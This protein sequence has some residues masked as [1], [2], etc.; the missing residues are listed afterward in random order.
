MAVKVI[1]EETAAAAISVVS[2]LVLEAIRE[3]PRLVLGLAAGRTMEPLYQELSTQYAAGNI[4][5]SRVT[6]FNLDEYI[7]L[8]PSDPNSYHH[9]MQEH[10]FK[11]VNLRGDNIHIPNGVARDLNVESLR[12]ERMIDKH[13]GV[14]LQLLGLGD[15][16]HVGFNEP[17][18][19]FHSRTRAVT[20]SPA[21]I[22]QNAAMFKKHKL[23]PRRAMTM[24]M[25]TIM[26]SRRCIMLVTGRHKAHILAKVLEGRITTDI[27]ATALR[28][29]R[30]CVIV[31]DKEA[32]QELASVE[33]VMRQAA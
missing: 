14:Q 21:T 32:A 28:M 16:G 12:Y 27:P 30:A 23:I 3:N 2:K 8:A 6:S 9:Y 10:L 1:I 5:F 4:D 29:H 13:G 33:Q 22:K 24:G 31:A 18:S 15:N 20:L 26:S 25:E 19:S 17:N 11:K 7:G